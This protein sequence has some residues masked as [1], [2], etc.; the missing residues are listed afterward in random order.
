MPLPVFP[1]G[2]GSIVGG[3]VQPMP[4]GGA[5]GAFSVPMSGVPPDCEFVGTALRAD[6]VP[7]ALARPS[8]NLPPEGGRLGSGF[9]MPSDAFLC[10]F[11][12]LFKLCSPRAMAD[13]VGR[14]G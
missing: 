3:M 10:G 9:A 12:L 6:D 7:V 8:P 13:V 4:G 2:G 5:D 14:G 1:F 11:S